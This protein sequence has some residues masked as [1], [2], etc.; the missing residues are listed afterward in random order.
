MAKQWRNS[1]ETVEKHWRNGETVAK[2]WRNAEATPAHVLR[3]P[4]FPPEGNTSYT[5]AYSARNLCLPSTT[6]QLAVATISQPSGSWRP[7]LPTS[8]ATFAA[9]TNNGCAKWAAA[10]LLLPHTVAGK[11]SRDD[12]RDLHDSRH[13]PYTVPNKAAAIQS[14]VKPQHHPAEASREAP[15][16]PESRLLEPDLAAQTT[17][18]ATP[19]SLTSAT[20]GLLPPPPAP[21]AGTLGHTGSL[22]I[23]NTRA[24]A[25]AVRLEPTEA[26][27]L[28][29]SALAAAED[30]PADED[31]APLMVAMFQR[32]PRRHDAET[33][34]LAEPSS[35]AP[36]PQIRRAV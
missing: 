11:A 16:R 17:A 33:A 15:S 1:G 30:D 19:L 32:K 2:Q 6:A 24:A 3:V 20:P 23:R 22:T 8:L 7:L 4:T 14:T 29:N 34:A 13:A 10:V 18:P 28:N 12:P 5:P 26:L 36:S 27:R 31:A 25:R 9:L 21:G 35:P